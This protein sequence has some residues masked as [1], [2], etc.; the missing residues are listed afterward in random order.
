[1]SVAPQPQQA[2]EQQQE[3]MMQFL[4]SFNL[5][6]DDEAEVEHYLVSQIQVRF[7]YLNTGS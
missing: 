5:I 1:M 3:E 6:G 2:N 7:P 4:D